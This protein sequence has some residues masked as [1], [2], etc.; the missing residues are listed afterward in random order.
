MRKRIWIIVIC[1]IAMIIAGEV[2]LYLHVNRKYA[3]SITSYDDS[4][5]LKLRGIGRSEQIYMGSQERYMIHTI[6]GLDLFKD[7]ISTHSAYL[8]S[9]SK[10]GKE[11]SATGQYLLCENQSYFFVEEGED[12]VVYGSQ[13]WDFMEPSD[14]TDGGGFVSPLLERHSVDANKPLLYPWE[15]TAGLRS[16]KDLVEYYENIQ[17]DLCLVEWDRN[18][19]YVP[20]YTFLEGWTAKRIKI[21]ANS[22]GIVITLVR[23]QTIS[24]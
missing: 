14:G 12:G 17:S 21:E 24:R 6:E 11:E 2:I 9:V 3:L 15:K 19:I 22:E 1:I 5:A 16:F 10:N 13:M 8:Y 7:V 4:S 23:S 18:T 20:I